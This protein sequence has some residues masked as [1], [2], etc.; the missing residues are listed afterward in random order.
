[1]K[2]ILI[3]KD[4]AVG[5]VSS[6]SDVPNGALAI[7][8]ENGEPL[9]V[10]DSPQSFP[11]IFI[12]QGTPDGKDTI[13]SDIIDINHIVGWS[14]KTYAA[15]QKKIV[16][17]GYNGTSGNITYEAGAE[18]GLFTNAIDD[19]DP[20][21][22][23]SG[24]NIL[25]T[26]D[27]ITTL[28]TLSKVHFSH[29]MR[30]SEIEVI[31]NGTTTDV[32]GVTFR[33]HYESDIVVASANISGTLNVGAEIRFSNAAANNVY[34][35]KEILAD[36]VTFKLDRPFLGTDLGNATIDTLASIT[37]FG[38]RVASKKAG[39]NFSF[40]LD[41]ETKLAES[42][43][44]YS[45]ESS[46]GSGT[47]DEIY[48]L[49]YQ[50]LANRGII[51]TDYLPIPYNR[52]AVEGETYNIYNIS[53]VHNS[54]NRSPNQAVSTPK[55]IKIAQPSDATT[56]KNAFETLLNGWIT[57]GNNNLINTVNL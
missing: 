18:Y 35:V 37:A 15:P 48:E 40:S 44:T 43:V 47:Y 41:S 2:D 12:V 14:G 33:T 51:N 28:S 56:N 7:F 25:G 5:S 32:S 21:W 3:G 29:R 50:A 53:Q 10:G 31:S 34:R 45:Q 52:Y 9:N 38:L 16:Y 30:H 11:R 54:I 4:V 1:M 39:L 49:E 6:P 46:K 22:P 23:N 55:L 36:G 27:M 20:T 13:K 24:I 8:K 17:V 57:A 19:Y 26:T 42:L